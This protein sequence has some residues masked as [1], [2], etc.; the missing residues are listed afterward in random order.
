[1]KKKWATV[2]A[3]VVL[4]LLVTTAFKVSLLFGSIYL[5]GGAYTLVRYGVRK[6][7][8]PV[9]WFAGGLITHLA[10]SEFLLPVFKSETLIDLV[11]ALT[12]FAIILFV[13][14]RIKKGKF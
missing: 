4:L 2:L 9:L 11:S 7:L 5:V 3:A 12:I 1:M 8:M 13:G 6:P 10:L 14:W